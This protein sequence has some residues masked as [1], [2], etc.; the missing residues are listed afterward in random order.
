MRHFHSGFRRLRHTIPRGQKAIRRAVLEVLEARHLLSTSVLTYHNDLV[1]DGVNSTETALSPANVKPGSFGKLYTTPLD[2]N[3][4]AEPL[5]VSGQMINAVINTPTPK[6]G[7]YDVVY[8]ETANDSIYAVNRINGEVLWQR[9]FL[10]TNAAGVGTT[11]GTDINNPLAA[12]TITAPTSV[13]VNCTD[14]SPTYGITG[15]PVIDPATNRMYVV[16]FTRE[17]IGGVAHFI[18]RIHAINLSDGTDMVVPY[19]IGDTTGTTTNSTSIYVYGTGDGNVSDPYNNTGKSVVQFNALRENQRAA[20]SLVNDVLYISWGS[21][22]D[23]TPYHGWIVSWNV[24]NL[25]SSGFVLNGVLCTSPNGAAA[26]I[27]SSGGG[28]SFDPGEANTFYFETGNGFDQGNGISL[29]GAGFPVGGAYFEA[30][31][32]VTTDPTTSPTNQNTNGWGFKV[33]DY[34]IPYNQGPLDNADQD[35]GSGS[36]LVLPD[37]AGVPGHSHLLLAAGKQGV[38]YVIDRDNM[39]KYSPLNDNVLN[40][41]PNGSGNKT[42]PVAVTGVLSTPV[43]FN[44][45]IYYVSGYSGPLQDFTIASSGILL[46]K[47]QSALGSFGYLP[48]SPVLSS[49]GGVNG[50]LWQTDRANNELHA[51]DANSLATELWNSAQAAGSVDAAGSVLKF[52]TPTVANGEVFLGTANSLVAYGLQ[53]PVNGAPAAPSLSSTA[54]SSTSISLNWTDPTVA[55]NTT[56]T[57][58]I[59]ELINGAWTGVTT[60]P[61]GTTLF[62]IGGLAPLTSYS[63]RIRGLNGAGYSPYSN[64]TIVSTTSTV[65][66]INLAGGFSGSGALLTYNGSSVLNGNAAQLVNNFSE[67]GSVFSD[68]LVDISKFSSTFQFQLSAGIHT[69]DGFTFTI[70]GSGPTALGNAG[71]GLGSETIAKS[72]SVKF[73]LYNNSGEGSDST[74]LYLNGA[75]PTI[76]ST[77]MTSSGVDLHSGDII[78]ALMGYDGTTLRESLTD[79]VTKAVFSTQYTVNIPSITGGNAYV[80]FTAGNGSL[81]PTAQDILNWT[82]SPNSTQAPT[83]PTGLGA[84]AASATSTSLTWTNNATNQTGFLLDRATDSGFTQNLVTQTLPATPTSFTDTSLGL[85]SGGTYFYRIRATNTAGSSANSNVASTSIPFAPAK[86]MNCVFDSVTA[87]SISLHWTDNAGV[88]ASGYHILRSVNGGAFSL[89]TTLPGL[90]T[91]PPT[92]YDWTDTG[93]TPGSNYNYHIQAFNI[94]GYN[95]FVG[96]NANTLTTAPAGVVATAGGGGIALSWA[97]PMGASS[98]NIYRGTT[99]G[100]ESATPVA[101]GI[102]ANSYTDTTV[103]G[104]VMYFYFVTAVNANVAPLNSESAASA[105]VSSSMGTATSV[106]GVI[107]AENYDSGG[108]GVGYSTPDTMNRGGAYRNDAIS[109]EPTT[110]TGGGYDVGWV[111]AG[112]WLDYTVNVAATGNYTL[113]VRVA[114]ANAGG[115]FHVEADGTNITGAMTMP[116]TGGWQTWTIVSKTVSLSAGTHVLRLFVDSSINTFL[117]NFNWISLAAVAGPVST[118]FSGTPAAAPGTIQAE[119]YDLGGEGVAYHA[120]DAVNRGGAYRNDGVSI[121]PT[122]DTGGGYDVAYIQAGEWLNYTVNVAATGNYT[123]SV[124]AASANA[125]GTFHVESDGTNITGSMTLGNTGGWQT[126]T[127]LTRT[128]A[129]TAGTHVLRLFVDSSV[130]TFFGNFNWI[131]LT[132]VAGAVSTPFSGTPAAVPGTIQAENYDLGGQGVA[133]NTTDTMNRGGVYRNDGVGIE[134]TSDIGGGY[135]VGWVHVGAWLKYTVNVATMGNY[136]LGVRV[137]SN[138][139]GGTFHVES[140]GVNITGQMT[141]ANT[142]GWQIWKT[143][144]QAVSL[145]A[146]THVLRLV[147]DS[148]IDADIANFNWISLT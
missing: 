26:G 50:I 46:A 22:C 102:T 52:A 76:P 58:S 94:A 41:V 43:Y 72:V 48:G 60:A 104:G 112:E 115:T 21:H 35:L 82:F 68:S 103:S 108:Q 135:D 73:D 66:A 16:A 147:I 77:D 30:V 122:T 12:T 133:Y 114:S 38:I 134:A 83:V 54:L 119:N 8:V 17:I 79:T 120:A 139:A 44:G 123:L 89:Y 51:Y 136:T 142:G 34:F 61:G 69:A 14:I 131:N 5:I 75:A 64:I 106:P 145:T 130:N 127:T 78:T 62:S 53:P 59:E 137:A 118:P 110:D 148:S 40:S 98:Y 27:W 7:I 141:V 13:D 19:L 36:P 117:G 92:V 88:T 132:A 25:A 4:Y 3:A 32:K 125:G 55:P 57:Y 74:G 29:T 39:G 9:N 6:S 105:Q 49:N 70:Q 109:I 56:A 24:A 96:G 2:G 37:S 101:T 93:L 100:G 84:T 33:V 80:G 121:E 71:G 87:A 15:T 18:Q 111:H 143:L 23:V 126:W 42:P 47:S 85:A 124:R 107:Q 129:I 28:L 113:G 91:K 99:S 128:V 90:S 67:A 10:S 144:T 95:D 116:D 65:A 146:G 20:L 11:A 45:T 63:F 138:S 140:D 1:H 31:V 81:S 97:A 86:A